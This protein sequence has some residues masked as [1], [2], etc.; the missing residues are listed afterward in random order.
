M[1]ES[2]RSIS[3][4]IYTILVIIAVVALLAGIIVVLVRGDQLGYK[5]PFSADASISMLQ[6]LVRP[7]MMS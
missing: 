3:S 4:D 1:A 7:I 2:R 5:S 6:D